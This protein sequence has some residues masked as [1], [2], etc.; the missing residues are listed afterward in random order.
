MARLAENRPAKIGARK[1]RPALELK[2]TNDPSDIDGGE[3]PTPAVIYG[4]PCSVIN[5]T[6]S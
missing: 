3:P 1:S 6:L 4:G 5:G 2:A